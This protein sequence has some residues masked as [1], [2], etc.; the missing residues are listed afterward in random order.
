MNIATNMNLTRLEDL[1]IQH[2]GYRQFVYKDSVGIS[3]VAVG[4]NLEDVGI[5]EDEARYLLRND[6]QNA[7]RE[8]SNN[9]SWFNDLDQVRQDAI[10]NMCFNLGITRLKGFK[11]MIKAML[12]K[13]YHEAAAQALDSKWKSQV[14]RRAGDIVHM[15]IT[16][17]YPD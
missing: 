2:E 15:F 6:I 16:G 7:R 4:R 17:K 13:D 5:S 10:V 12:E 14:G 3:T 9:F 1:L 11:K 8:C